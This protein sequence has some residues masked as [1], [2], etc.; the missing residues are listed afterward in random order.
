MKFKTFR[1]HF[2]DL[3]TLAYVLTDKGHSLAT[4]CRAFG[5]EYIKEEAPTHGVISPDYI[6]YCRRDVRASAA[7]LERQREEF[8]RH[9][10]E[11]DPWALRSPASL[12]KAYLRKGGVQPPRIRAKAISPVQLGQAMSAFHGGRAECH[13][14][15]VP[16][17]VVNV[18]VLSMYPT[19]NALG[20]FWDYAMAEALTTVDVTAEAKAILQFT[21]LDTC[22]EVSHWPQLRFFAEIIPDGD[23]LPIKAQYRAGHR[24]YSTG[25]NLL[26]A[27]EPFW[28]SGY[29]LAASVL[30]T[31]KVPTIR[32]A[33]ALQPQGRASSL[34][35]IKLRG[36]LEVDLAAEDPFVRGIELRKEVEADEQRSPEER[37]RLAQFLKVFANAGSFGIAAEVQP[38]AGPEGTR[39]PVVV[40]GRSRPFTGKTAAPERPGEYFLPPVAALITSAARLFLTILQRLV[41]DAGGTYVGT[42]TDSMFI[43]ATPEG[44]PVVCSGGK[45]SRPGGPPEITALSW[46]QVEGIIERLDGLKP[47]RPSM[48]SHQ[49]KLED[50]NFVAGVQN[51]LYAFMLSAKRY[52]LYNIA[53]DGSIVIRKRSEHGLGQYFDPRDPEA[54]EVAAEEKDQNCG[55]IADAWRGW[56]EETLGRPA[57][58]PPAWHHRPALIRLTLSTPTLLDPFMTEQANRSYADQVKPFNFCLRAEVVAGG[59]PIGA[60]PEHCQL[61]GA[62][63]TDP[64]KWTTMEWRDKATGVSCRITISDTVRVNC[65]QVK[66]MGQVLAE[67]RR[68]PEVKSADAQGSS[69]SPETVGVLRPRHVRP[70]AVVHVGKESNRLEDVGDGL[71]TDW[72]DV[73]D[74]FHEPS[75]DPWEVEVLPALRMVSAERIAEATG[76][77]VRT[78]HRIRNAKRPPPPGTRHRLERLA[79]VIQALANEGE[80]EDL[81]WGGDTGRPNQEAEGQA[82]LTFVKKASRKRRPSGRRRRNGMR[83][84]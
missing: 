2:L 64:R 45:P 57:P 53:A 82:K 28:Y 83:S 32:R 22:F 29:D 35:P 74:V 5:A 55:W 81:E 27:H 73:L 66:S 21:T 17:P 19:V 41:E 42:D 25:I 58:S 14:R 31:G 13:I 47:Y 30:L 46:G 23:R 38:E 39:A 36:E 26:T 4:A 79:R 63:E 71:V 77:G 8:D 18:D 3:K 62:Y 9:P 75:A 67:Y 68:H 49:L 50:Q 59:T 20:R 76:L 56:V 44:G 51:Q 6:T 52:C 37:K 11:V 34:R 15:G 33:F 84:L 10:V 78:V 61:L 12:A 69:C 60:D 80:L 65:A 72:D 54:H 40:Y 70:K 24:E 16:V 1:G 43:V 48:K 7:L